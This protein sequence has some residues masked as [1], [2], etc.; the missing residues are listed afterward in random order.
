MVARIRE[1]NVKPI[2]KRGSELKYALKEELRE[3]TNQNICKQ[4]S[5]ID[6]EVKNLGCKWNF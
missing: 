5:Q 2:A 3:S 6:Y 4:E 1:V